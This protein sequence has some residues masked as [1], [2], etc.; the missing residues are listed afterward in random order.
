MKSQ[1]GKQQ[2]LEQNKTGS[3]VATTI[4]ATSRKKDTRDSLDSTAVVTKGQRE[5][6]AKESKVSGS[7]LSEVSYCSKI[8][9]CVHVKV[10]VT[11]ETEE[12]EEMN[13]YADR[14]IR[15]VKKS[16]QKQDE[17]EGEQPDSGIICLTYIRATLN[18]LCL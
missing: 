17:H 16:I 13:K 1:S 18:L 15:I 11:A 8:I 14:F 4:G 10:K 6:E 3:A 7:S 12:L 9:Y 2:L 5:N